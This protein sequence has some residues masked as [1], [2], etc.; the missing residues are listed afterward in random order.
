MQ[1]VTKPVSLPFTYFIITSITIYKQQKHKNLKRAFS[2]TL[3]SNQK[4]KTVFPQFFHIAYQ[5]QN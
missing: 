1:N 5:Y 2:H 3:N 4:V